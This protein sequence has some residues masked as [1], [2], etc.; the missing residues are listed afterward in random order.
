[1]EAEPME[2]SQIGGKV[3]ET[4]SNYLHMTSVDVEVR[5]GRSDRD[6]LVREREKELLTDLSCP[7]LSPPHPLCRSILSRN[8]RLLSVSIVVTRLR[9][10]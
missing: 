6:Q 4:H 1:M 9:R 3:D 7:V 8:V 2:A 10:G 5:K